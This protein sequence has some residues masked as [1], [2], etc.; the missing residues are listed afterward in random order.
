MSFLSDKK[1]VILSPI[2]KK[3]DQNENINKLE[4]SGFV[5]KR[6]KGIDV[7][8]NKKSYFLEDSDF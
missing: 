4:K 3:S 1:T 8:K 5:L 7:L 6:G 2:K